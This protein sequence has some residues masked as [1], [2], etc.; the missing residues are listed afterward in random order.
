M[1][2][3][4]IEERYN[5]ALNAFHSGDLNI[6]ED[7]LTEIVNE[8]EDFN[9]NYFLAVVKSQLGKYEEAIKYYQNTISKA[10]N[11]P[12]AYFNMALCQQKLERQDEA[13]ESYLK[14]VEINPHLDDAYNNIAYIYQEKGDLENA[15]KYLLKTSDNFFS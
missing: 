10:P 3:R 2:L 7:L 1:V 12:E 4:S 14:A 8:A 6:A 9:S 5:E 15:E 11:H 13:L